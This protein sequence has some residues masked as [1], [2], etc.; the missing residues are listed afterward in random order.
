MSFL[1]VMA[2]SF[3]SSVFLVS[4]HEWVKSGQHLVDKLCRIK[5]AITGMNNSGLLT[6]GPSFMDK[7]M[8]SPDED[9]VPL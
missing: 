2:L 6:Q 4:K 9:S 8:M 7:E 3:D 5:K 1:L